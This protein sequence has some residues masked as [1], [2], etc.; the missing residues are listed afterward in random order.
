LQ[1]VSNNACWFLGEFAAVPNNREIIRP[2]L[3]QIANKLCDLC[4]GE[5]LN[6]S[7]AINVAI[8]FGRLGLVDPR[9]LALKYLERI[10]KQWCITMRTLKNGYE[11]DTSYRGLIQMIPFNPVPVIRYFPHLCS[12]FV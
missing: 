3:A 10:L 5:S 2:F 8:T 1:F 9:E 7:L 4:K 12:A 6:K 11:K